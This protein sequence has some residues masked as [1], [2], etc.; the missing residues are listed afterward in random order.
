[1]LDSY[2]AREDPAYRWEVRGEG[3]VAGSEY[4]ELLLTSQEWR[5]IRWHHQLF[6]IWPTTLDEDARHALLFLHGGRWQP[7]MESAEGLTPLPGEATGLALV[8]EYLGAPLAVLRQVPFQ[9]L[10]DGLV[11]DRLISYT[12]DRFLETGEEDWPLLLPMVKSVVRAMDAMQELAGEERGLSLEGFT[13]TGASKRGWTT[14]LSGAADDRV[15]AIAPM[16]IDFLDVEA[17][18]GHQ[19]E[20]W[21]DYSPRIGAYIDREIHRRLDT[22]AG[23]ALLDVVD[24]LRYRERLTRPKLVVVGTNDPYW[25][26]DAL[27]LYWDDLPDPRRVLYLPNT[28]HGADDFP[29]VAGGLV[30]LHRHVAAGETLPEPRWRFRETE[31]SLRLRVESDAVPRSVTAWSATAPE[32]DFREATWSSGPCEPEEDGFTCAVERPPEGYTALF[33]ELEYVAEVGPPLFL[34]TQLR[35]AAPRGRD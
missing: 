15:R 33:A 5:G 11:E 34:S 19:V 28:G 6:V 35:M 26:L 12:F 17:H 16:V 22:G 32:R 2:V 4:T 23:Q 9:P 8:A 25:P 21:G 14:W 31:G 18:L 30:A 1:M 24:P 20:T 3:E 27:N 29:R 13:V 10:F 7:G